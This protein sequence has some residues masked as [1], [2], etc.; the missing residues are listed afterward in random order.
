MAIC[1]FSYVKNHWLIDW[2]INLCDG[3][4]S[5]IEELGTLLI[6][7]GHSAVLDPVP[8]DAVKRWRVPRH[9]YGRQRQTTYVHVRRRRY[10]CC[11]TIQLHLTATD[12]PD[13]LDTH[14]TIHISILDISPP[15]GIHSSPD[16]S[17]TNR[18]I[19]GR[20]V[21]RR[22]NT[23]NTQY[24]K[25]PILGQNVLRRIANNSNRNRLP[26]HCANAENV[27]SIV[28]HASHLQCRQ[29]IHRLCNAMY[30]IVINIL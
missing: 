16:V 13:T 9:L 6:V 2:L 21:Y 11:N 25:N 17:F 19:S 7:V 1:H 22:R 3:V 20:N 30:E 8:R 24:G 26:L 10:D 28:I 5:S 4:R 23:R 15:L 14:W 18:L 29:N 27:E 12:P